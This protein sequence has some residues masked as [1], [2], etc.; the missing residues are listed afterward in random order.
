MPVER[1][2]GGFGRRDG[3]TRANVDVSNAAV[4]AAK[5]L[6]RDGEGRLPALRAIADDKAE[7]AD[8]KRSAMLSARATQEALAAPRG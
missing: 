3:A 4:F 6:G 5:A 8:V 7:I 2:A 1:P